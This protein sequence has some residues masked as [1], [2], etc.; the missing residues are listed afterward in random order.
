MPEH[1]FQHRLEFRGYL[2]V[3][4]FINSLPDTALPGVARSIAFLVYYIIGVRK[5]VAL[6]NLKLAFPDKPDRW[7]KRTTYYSY[8][9]FSMVILEFMSMNKWSH[10][11]LA[12][13]MRNVDID[14]FLNSVQ[15]GKGAIVVSGHFGNWEIGIG[16]LHL[17][18]VRS[19]VIQQRQKN[20]LVNDKMKSL[21]E[22]WGMEIILPRGA[23][24][25]CLHALE[26]KRMI[27]ILGDQDAG[28]RG[29]VV[30]FLG[31]P[32]STHIGGAMIH[33][34]S[35]V[36]LFLGACT[37][38]NAHKFD[39]VIE[40]IPTDGSKRITEARLKEVIEKYSLAMEK[41]IRKHP[42]QYFWLHRRWK[43]QNRFS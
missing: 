19:S 28:E 9:H 1:S 26:R 2:A 25:N 12:E 15:T 23:V 5:K 37:R 17:K 3:E 16:Y 11:K 20:L 42:E 31:Q 34:K 41:H 21:R 35:G 33:L 32:S 40:P 8:L 30:P 18:N 7:Y 6:E 38:V 10:R 27:A 43:S 4:K 39:F 24:Q 22:K 13:R 14:R 29:I 36:P